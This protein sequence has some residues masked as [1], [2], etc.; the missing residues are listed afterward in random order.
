MQFVVDAWLER[1]DPILRLLNADT[2]KEIFRCSSERLLYLLSS[3]Q[4][5]LD[6]IED[7]ALDTYERL[8]LDLAE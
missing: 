4:L 3:G 2:G 1:K 5:T 7:E 8:G 6:E